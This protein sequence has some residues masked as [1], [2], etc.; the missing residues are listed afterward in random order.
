MDNQPEQD[1]EIEAVW[2]AY[3]TTGRILHL[4]HQPWYEWKIWRPLVRQLPNNPR[5][6]ICYYPFD[7]IGGRLSKLLLGV[8]PS[9]MNPQLC[10][11]C[12]RFAN[13]YR[14]GTELEVSM[15]FA[16]VRGSTSLA[17]GIRPT[18][19]SKQINRFYR[20]TTNVL[21]DTNAFV[22]KLIGDEVVGFYV[23]GFAGPDHARVAV[24]AAKRIL[25]VTGH[26]DPSGPWIPVGIGVHT[27]IAYIGSV[28]VADGM[29]DIVILGDA[30]NT[31]AR[32]ASQAGPGEVVISEATRLAAGLEPE[33]MLSRQFHLK[34]KSESVDA[35]V[36][37]L[38]GQTPESGKKK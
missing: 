32:L 22:E 4:H 28:E 38:M 20:A 34:G 13:K 36:L 5:C 30:P 14:G 33:G 3:L 16:D 8:E 26:H 18:E 21:F 15:L 19:F 12:E 23:P 1:P 35:W 2:H 27:G 6:R 7:G 29:S 11:V 25:E 24:S 9:K 31:T 37:S 17:E 10:N